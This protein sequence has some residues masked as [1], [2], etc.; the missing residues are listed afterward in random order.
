MKKKLFGFIFAF[1]FILTGAMCLTACGGDPSY[2]AKDFTEVYVGYDNQDVTSSTAYANEGYG[3]SFS[4]ILSK[5]SLSLVYPNG[6]KKEL[7]QENFSETE[8]QEIKQNYEEKYYYSD[9][10]GNYT[11]YAEGEPSHTATLDAGSYKIV[12]SFGQKSA[13]LEITVSK[14]SDY[15]KN[16]T[17]VIGTAPSQGANSKYKYDAKSIKANVYDNQMLVNESVSNIFALPKTLVLSEENETGYDEVTIYDE[18]KYRVTEGQ[19]LKE[20]FEQMI[21]TLESENVSKYNIRLA[22]SNFVDHFGRNIAN[23]K[24]TDNSLIINTVELR[25]GKYY[26]LASFADKNH[27]ERLTMPN[28]KLLEV[29]KG[30]FNLREA[31]IKSDTGVALSNE[32]FNQFI[33]DL[34]LTVQYTFNTYLYNGAE[35]KL[36]IG[37]TKAL[38]AKFLNDNYCLSY[39]SLNDFNINDFSIS[40][41]NGT[42]GL[43]AGGFRLVET[44]DN[45]DIR[46]DCSDNNT[47]AKAVYNLN[48]IYQEY[49]EDD[50]AEYDVD[51]QF[52][53]GQVN[54]PYS[55]SSTIEMEYTGQ[56]IN[57]I[58]SNGIEVRDPDFVNILNA[59]ATAVGEYTTTITLK[60]T[61]NYE[62]KSEDGSSYYY[63]NP[64]GTFTWNIKKM[65][66]ERNDFTITGTY[67]TQIKDNNTTGL[68]F[69]YEEGNKQIKVSLTNNEK[70]NFIKEYCLGIQETFGMTWSLRTG[71]EGYNVVGV[72]L[73]PDGDDVIITYTGLSEYSSGYI[74]LVCTI[75]ETSISNE[76]TI[77]VQVSINKAKFTEEQEAKILSAIKAEKN[78]TE[79]RLTEAGKIIITR[80]DLILPDVL[81]D[82]TDPNN[83]PETAELGEWH[84]YRGDV[85]YHNGDKVEA[86][87]NWTFKFIPKDGMFDGYEVYLTNDTD[88]VFTDA[89]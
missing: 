25:P 33:K 10:N 20:A 17:I 1:A 2:K 81:P 8:I 45:K 83:L 24:N 77:D 49:Y 28:S 37:D 60:D 3:V 85:E 52:T 71:D 55:S 56:A 4:D 53:K 73:S 13:T 6:Q 14:L 7:N 42:V 38:T 88:I 11:K 66:I 64:E 80:P 65:T 58:G 54:K 62:Y 48:A 18:R 79:Y 15:T 36:T 39:G 43:A 22:K 31:L 40:V 76:F 75:N 84:L 30:Q 12:F 5:T 46:F 47:K 51:L 16:V 41:G 57:I 72:N 26:T 21:A 67:G 50:L 69:V 74:N 19:D 68:D 87:G 27:E 70:Y 61:V 78:G 34:G 29:T 89:A 32:E 23:D 86:Y 82:Y 59:T 63:G 9:S 44:K 35:P